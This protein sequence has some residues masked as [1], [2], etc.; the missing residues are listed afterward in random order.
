MWY[1][2]CTI[3]LYLTLLVA[4]TEKKGGGHVQG[5]HHYCHK[6]LMITSL[7]CQLRIKIAVIEFLL[8]IF[9]VKKNY[10]IITH[11]CNLLFTK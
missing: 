8:V 3:L 2:V 11:Y 4:C 6:Y 5:G 7:N 9:P 1:F 10:K